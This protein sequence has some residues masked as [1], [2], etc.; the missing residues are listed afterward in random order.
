M[1]PLAVDLMKM[2][3]EAAE[4]AGWTDEGIMSVFC[5]FVLKHNLSTPLAKYVK[6]RLD[7]E[8]EK[9]SLWYDRD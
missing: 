7:E 8:A 9:S 3:D 5:D 4:Q 2:I 1:D 6:D